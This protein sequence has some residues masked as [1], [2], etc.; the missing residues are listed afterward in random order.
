MNI[1][2]DHKLEYKTVIWIHN[3]IMAQMVNLQE[4]EHMYSSLVLMQENTGPEPSTSMDATTK[5]V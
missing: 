1:I 3:I 5:I 4:L 2:A